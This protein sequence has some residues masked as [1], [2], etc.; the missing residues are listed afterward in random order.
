MAYANDIVLLAKN[1]EALL[2]TMNTLKRFLKER[3]LE[4]IQK[5]QK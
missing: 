3:K 1:R 4:F 5:K 2:D